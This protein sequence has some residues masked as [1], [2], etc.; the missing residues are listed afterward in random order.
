M[1]RRLAE[2]ALFQWFC[3]VDRLE[4]VRVPSKSQLARY[5]QWLPE[6]AGAGP[7]PPARA[8]GA[9]DPMPPRG[10]T[11]SGWPTNWNWTRCGWTARVAADIHFPVDWVLLRD[12][13]R[14]LMK[15]TG[16]IR[17]HRLK[18]RMPAPEQFLRAMNQQCI[19]MVQAGKR[20]D[21]KRARK[22]VLR[23]MKR[24]SRV[25]R[26]HARRHRDL[27]DTHWQETDWTWARPSRCWP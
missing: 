22:R 9:G 5:F 18:R 4:E 1:S 3:G 15:A 24:L 6:A 10:S 12:A 19:A 13:T 7:G 16:L 26:Q 21:A 8:G 11:G 2:C 27:L 20:A 17:A 25:V 23:E 14:T